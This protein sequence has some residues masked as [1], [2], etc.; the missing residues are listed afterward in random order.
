MPKTPKL[1][2]SPDP[3]AKCGRKEIER[4]LALR[5]ERLDLESQA[6]SNATE[7]RELAAQIMRYAIANGGKAR[8]LTRCGHRLSVIEKP[9]SVAWQ[10]EFRKVVG[11]E[12]VQRLKDAAPP[13]DVLQ[14][15]AI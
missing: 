1:S 14:V 5:Q 13:R 15:E 10:S 7:E 12:E 6:R 11:A 3:P 8:S 4:Y 2:K 9:G